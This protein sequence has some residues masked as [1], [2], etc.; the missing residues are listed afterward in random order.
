MT[1][2]TERDWRMA[3]DSQSACNLSGIVFQFA[4]TMTRICEDT[5]DDGTDAKNRHP[6]ARLYA[7]QIMFLACGGVGDVESYGRAHDVVRK[8]VEGAVA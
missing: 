3:S 1:H 8:R 6:I 4:D 2:L 5:R 7:E